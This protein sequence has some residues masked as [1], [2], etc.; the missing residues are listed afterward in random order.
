MAAGERLGLLCPRCLGFIEL[1]DGSASFEERCGAIE[2]FT[3]EHGAHLGPTDT[4][5][6][7]YDAEDIEIY[8][9][10]GSLGKRPPVRDPRGYD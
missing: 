8:E 1:P 3:D 6:V 4:I 5:D 10:I 7:V 2:G 9:K